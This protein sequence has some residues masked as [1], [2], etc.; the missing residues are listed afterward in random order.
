MEWSN[1]VNKILKELKYKNK[2]VIES[3]ISNAIAGFENLVP[4]ECSVKELQTEKERVIICLDGT[5][6]VLDKG[7]VINVPIVVHIFHGY[8]DIA[9]DVLVKPDRRMV[10]L[11]NHYVNGEGRMFLPLLTSWKDQKP[12][13]DL[14][15]LVGMV[16]Q[17]FSKSCPVCPK[18]KCSQI[19]N[20]NRRGS[21][22]GV[23]SSV[24]SQIFTA[25]RQSS[26]D[27]TLGRIPAIY[28]QD[29]PT[30]YPTQNRINSNTAFPMVYPSVSPGVQR[31]QRS[32]STPSA[33]GSPSGGSWERRQ[34][35]PAPFPT[36]SGGFST[37]SMSLPANTSVALSEEATTA[38]MLE[39]VT[40]TMIE[41]TRTTTATTTA[42][43]I[44]SGAQY[45]NMPA[46][47]APRNTNP[48]ASGLD[49]GRP[50]PNPLASSGLDLFRT[51]PCPVVVRLV[52]IHLFLE[53]H[54]SEIQLAV[55]GLTT[56]VNMI[57]LTH[58]QHTAVNELVV[59]L[60]PELPSKQKKI[61]PMKTE[62]RP[63]GRG[64]NDSTQTEEEL[65]AMKAQKI[66]A[67]FDPIAQRSA[68]LDSF[69]RDKMV[70][71][72]STSE[73]VLDATTKPDF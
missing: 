73:Q 31:N 70:E 54:I 63:L 1:L 42:R 22:D 24:S 32:L 19:S 62:R 60:P 10:L 11:P 14:L 28:S 4:R 50:V 21:R 44:A 33:S 66:L 45:V 5:I 27:G 46:T 56:H 29:F 23:S 12:R 69:R 58:L 57:M 26:T 15:T 52:A 47:F 20:G 8:P 41:K 53:I 72:W 61:A 65:L 67:M 38:T 17:M 43:R 3:D 36:S 51:P 9:P 30:V 34:N 16:Q 13:P 25:N 39:E 18:H 35:A 64:P 2:K 68:G 55:K 6:P 7:V 40:I 48:F 37:R 71:Q 49:P 59:E